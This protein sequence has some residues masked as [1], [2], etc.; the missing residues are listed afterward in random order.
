MTR[1]SDRQAESLSDSPAPAPEPSPGTFD[2]WRWHVEG[3]F[4]AGLPEAQGYVHI[5][6]FV[7]WLVDRSLVDAGWAGG[8]KTGPVLAAMAERGEGPCA[9]LEV[10][11]GKLTE[12][13][14]SAEGRAF[15]GAYYAPEYG[16]ARDWRQIYGRAADRYAIPG[17]W[18]TFDRVAPAIDRRYAAWV[19]GG[20]PELMPLP[21]LMGA[22]ARL[23]PRR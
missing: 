13:M 23:V 8:A 3:Q 10:T 18:D 21:G 6:I 1:P 16:Y 9:L 5:G 19:R 14:L 2:D 22:L 7:A 4:P 11:A 20:R 17:T 15:A 12:G